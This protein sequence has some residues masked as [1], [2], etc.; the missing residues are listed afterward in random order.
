[1]K[2]LGAGCLV[3]MVLACIGGG[4][5]MF[6]VKDGLFGKVIASSDAQP[7]TAFAVNFTQNN[8]EDHEV[9]V[10]LD[11]S[12][13]T[14]PLTG[15]LQ[16]TANGQPVA[17]YPLNFQVTTGGCFNPAGGGRS[18]CVNYSHAGSSMSGRLYLFK[19][20]TQ[21][22]GAAVAITGTLMAPEGFVSRR[23]QFQ[24]RE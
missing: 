23:L 9:W 8:R 24:V 10:D 7:N 18:G 13:N 21:A 22:S 14:G 15:Q 2:V 4:V 6:L 5:A 12:Q 11:V 16:V 3:V 1:M 19:I 20:P 17:Q